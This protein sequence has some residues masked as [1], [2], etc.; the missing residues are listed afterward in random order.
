MSTISTLHDAYISKIESTLTEYT[1]LSNPYD[2]EANASLFLNM[3]FGVGFGPGVNSQRNLKPKLS[4]NR[5]FFVVLVNRI[6]ATENDSAARAAITKSLMEDHLSL[7]QA[8]ESDPTFGG[9]CIKTDYLTDNGIE[10]LTGEKAKYYL[11]ELSFES[12]YFEL[13]T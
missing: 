6:T 8:I 3:G 10:F 9:T 2:P 5:E 12:E 1:Q 11:I 4:I 7:V 13:L